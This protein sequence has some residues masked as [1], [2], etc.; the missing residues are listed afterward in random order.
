[1]LASAT[2]ADGAALTALVRQMLADAGAG[3]TIGTF[4]AV[5]EFHHVADDPPPVVAVTDE[6][7]EVVTA[8][9]GIRVS[10]VAGVRAVAYES[11]GGPPYGW[12]H[13]LAFCL[14][15]ADAAMGGRTV[16]TELGPDREAL[17]DT[18]RGARMFDMGLGAPHIDFCVRTIDGALIEVLRRAAGTS[19]L[20]PGDQTM[21]AIVAASPHRVCRSRLGRIEVYQPIPPPLPGAR[22]PVGPHTHVLP[23]LLKSRRTHSANAPIPDGWVPA[24][25]LH[26]ANPVFTSLGQ[27]KPFDAAAHAA[28]QSLLRAYGL[29]DIVFEKERIARAVLAGEKPQAYTAASSRA[30]RTAARVALRQLFHTHATDANLQPWLAAFDYGASQTTGAADAQG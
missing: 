11:L 26:P 2:T 14:P 8:R 20:A 30:A 23:D 12:L 27:P 4:G 15:H 1:M 29:P 22:S 19:L 10:L 16:L 17:R 28:F 6:S 18:E 13:A 3:W 5:A 7:Q 24:L 21:A 25:T 9:G